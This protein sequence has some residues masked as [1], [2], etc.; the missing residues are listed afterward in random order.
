MTE[1]QMGL[2]LKNPTTK[3][4]LVLMQKFAEMELQYKDLK[5]EAE[6]A[7]ETIKEA[8]IDHGIDKINIDIDGIT[9]FITLATRTS[10]KAEDIE[11]VD[12]QYIEPTLDTDKIKAQ[13]TLYGQIPAGVQKATTQYIIKK[14]KME[15]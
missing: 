6:E 3:K 4:A 15:K 13:E 2:I 11:S 1:S 7:S 5:K 10:Y 9:G 14:I 12:A 8:M